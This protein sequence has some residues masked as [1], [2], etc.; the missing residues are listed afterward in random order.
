MDQFFRYVIN[1]E[2]RKDRRGEMENQLRRIGW[3]AEFSQSVKPSRLGGFPSFGAR[4]CFLSHLDALQRG[5]TTGNH[6]LIMEDDLNF[7]S[8]FSPHWSKAVEALKTTD[9]SIFYP[10]HLLPRTSDG[11][12]MIDSEQGIR[13][14]H[15]VVFHSVAVPRIIAGLQKIL[16][17]PAGHP[18]GGPM[19]VDGAYSTL[20]RQN[21]DLRTFIFSPSLGTQRS[22]R[23][24]IADLRSFDRIS[25]LE[26][27]MIALRR[28]KQRTR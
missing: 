19:H 4:G 8:D 6:V 17:R 1:L 25:F 20:R 22:S 18:L 11:L 28:I 14:A 24:D 15:F 3:S 27:L 16:S 9:W 23:S 26:P 2:S 10:A 13:C 7:V 5:E 12:L 21:P